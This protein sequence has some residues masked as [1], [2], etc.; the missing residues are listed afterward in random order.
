MELWVLGQ[1]GA[2]DQRRVDSRS[3]HRLGGRD[4]PVQDNAPLAILLAA[5]G[6]AVECFK[7]DRLALM[8][9]KIAG[10]RNWPVSPS[11]EREEET[12]ADVPEEHPQEAQSGH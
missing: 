5:V 8:L 12:G 3:V 4:H 1:N 6:E 7:C 11:P 2:Q 9:L 10:R